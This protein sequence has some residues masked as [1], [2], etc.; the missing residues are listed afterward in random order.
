MKTFFRKG[1][2]LI[3]MFLM[4]FICVA[5]GCAP[6]ENAVDSNEV[7]S[8][9]AT[10][11][12]RVDT[13]EPEHGFEAQMVV[14]DV[15]NFSS[16]LAW[17]HYGTGN[18][19]DDEHYYGCIDKEGKV[20]FAYPR[21]SINEKS[22]FIKGAAYIAQTPYYSY[23]RAEGAEY[24]IINEQ[25][26]ILASSVASDFDSIVTYGGGYF[27]CY[28]DRSDFSGASSCYKVIDSTGAVVKEIIYGKDEFSHS[29]YRNNNPTY[30]GDGIFMFWRSNTT[31]V[32]NIPENIEFSCE[33]I[34]TFSS[35][36]E[37]NDGA[38]FL[39]RTN[40]LSNI[41]QFKDGS[42][43][44]VGQ[45]T[46]WGKIPSECYAS[47]GK[48]VL[49]EFDNNPAG[50]DKCLSIVYYSVTDDAYYPLDA[51]IDNMYTSM[52][53]KDFGQFDYRIVD[54]CFLEPV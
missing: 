11:D 12:E 41:V 19:I 7:S 10:S 13:P 26:E 51:F 43:V 3:L 9:G 47:E 38:A 8:N 34:S 6:D 40:N 44:E 24:Y 30:A 27:V 49:G 23:T 52:P 20:L 45:M 28:E 31:D 54:D 53:V 15:E 42:Q 22:E 29:D 18:T 4:I 37:F 5:T 48:V 16:G 25:G 33:G 35:D 21:D 50:L 14:T 17:I 2:L 39:Q 32:Y 1:T 46:K 36:V